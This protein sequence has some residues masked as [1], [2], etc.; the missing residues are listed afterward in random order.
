MRTVGSIAELFSVTLSIILWNIWTWLSILI[1]KT[2]L[3][4][5]QMY[6]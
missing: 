5:T 1:G 4:N 2:T 3:F 6:L